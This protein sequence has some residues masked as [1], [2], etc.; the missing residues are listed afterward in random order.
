MSDYDT[1][2]SSDIDEDLNELNELN[3]Y[4]LIENEDKNNK[5]EEEENEKDDDDILNLEEEDN[6]DNE[7]D[8]EDDDD[9]DEKLITGE[10]YNEL[11][12]KKHKKMSEIIMKKDNLEVHNIENC[13]SNPYMTNFEFVRIFSIRTEQIYR[14]SKCLVAGVENENPMQQ[15]MHE[16]KNGVVPLLIIRTLP[17]GIK[18]IFDVNKLKHKRLLM[19]H[20]ENIST[21]L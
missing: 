17:C 4:T 12:L 6:E 2:Y 20:L 15:A 9:D 11:F 19:Q 16:I 5:I 10:E 18:E 8:D 21:N 14:G 3:A 1:D 7:E 13:Q